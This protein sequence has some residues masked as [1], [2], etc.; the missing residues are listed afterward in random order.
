MEMSEISKVKLAALTEYAERL[1]QENGPYLHAQLFEI[2]RAKARIVNSER[3]PK[4]KA[5]DPSFFVVA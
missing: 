5:I 3:K 1:E 4:T 2:A